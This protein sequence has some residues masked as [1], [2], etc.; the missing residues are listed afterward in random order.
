MRNSFSPPLT[1]ISRASKG[2]LGQPVGT[3]ATDPAEVGNM[4]TTTRTD[5]KD[6]VVMNVHGWGPDDKGPAY[7]VMGNPLAQLPSEWPL[8]RP[9]FASREERLQRVEL[10][11]GY[12]WAIQRKQQIHGVSVL[13]PCT[14]CGMP[15][16]GWCDFC[17]QNPAKAVCSQCGGTDATVL[18]SCHDCQLEAAR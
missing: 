5:K 15:T 9:L 2:P 11:C 7:D 8:A 16:G 17:T 13:P 10:R 3:I 4:A 12:A 1:F 14:W 18:A 6:S